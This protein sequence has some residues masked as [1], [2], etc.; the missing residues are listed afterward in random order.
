MLART[1]LELCNLRGVAGEAR[2]SYV[3]TEDDLFRLVR[4]LVALEAAAEF[5]VGFPLMALAA[6]RDYLPVGRRMAIVA[7][8]TGYLCLVG[9]AFGVNV[10]RRLCVALDAVCAGQ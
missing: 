5:V 6:E 3:T 10:S 7:V 4:V 8:L 2:I 1:C 9:S